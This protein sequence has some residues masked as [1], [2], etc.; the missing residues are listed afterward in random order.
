MAP[1]GLF[2]LKHGAEVGW[3]GGEQGEEPITLW[4]TRHGTAMR[5]DP[6]VP[7]H[8]RTMRQH[9]RHPMLGEQE[10]PRT[11]TPVRLGTQPHGKGASPVAIRMASIA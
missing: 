9:D 8:P 11:L 3:Q 10:I 7:A 6:T 4:H 5:L 1:A 2:T